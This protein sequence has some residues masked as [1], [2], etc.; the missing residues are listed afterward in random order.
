MTALATERITTATGAADKPRASEVFHVEHRC[1]RTGHRVELARYTV[2]GGEE[3][4]LY[5]QRVDG[6]VRF[7]PEEPV[8][9]DSALGSSENSGCCPREPLQEDGSSSAAR[10]E[11]ANDDGGSAETADAATPR[12]GRTGPRVE[13]ARY[14]IPAGDRVLYGQRVDGVVRL[15]DVPLEA[16]G[17]AYLVERGL[18]EEGSNANAALHALIAD[19]LRQ[20]SVLDAVPMAEGH[21]RG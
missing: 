10:Q 11:R 14:S 17:R 15:T 8:V 21:D 12:R 9:L 18:E 4:V 16:G 5:G 13:L 3:R 2:G 1:G 6:V 7:L 19:Y 20:A